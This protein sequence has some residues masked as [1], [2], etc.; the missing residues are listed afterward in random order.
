MRRLWPASLAGQLV[1]IVLI[2]LAL[3]QAL[4]FLIFADER[5][6]ALRAA[7]REQILARTAGLAR[8]LGEI[9][10]ALQDSVLSAS[11]GAQ[12]R[13]GLADSGAVDGRAPGHGRNRLARRLRALLDG[14]GGRPVLVDVRDERRIGNLVGFAFVDE[15]SGQPRHWRHQPEPV[16]LTLAVQLGDGRWLNARTTFEPAPA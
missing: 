14:N 8:L 10:Q 4:S 6:L 12:V 2:A 15:A 5:R 13:F 9:P 7:S 16:G 11:S 1:L 3:G